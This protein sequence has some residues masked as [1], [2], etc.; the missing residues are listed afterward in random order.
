MVRRRKGGTWTGN[1]SLDKS[2]RH[3]KELGGMFQG[4]VLTWGGSCP[5]FL[6]S[7]RLVILYKRLAKSWKGSGE[8]GGGGRGEAAGSCMDCKRSWFTN[9]FPRQDKGLVGTYSMSHYCFFFLLFSSRWRK[10][11]WSLGGHGIPSHPKA[12]SFWRS[13]LDSLV[14]EEMNVP[15]GTSRKGKERKSV[16]PKSV[17]RNRQVG[18]F[19]ESRPSV[20]R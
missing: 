9:P 12:V 15:R 19:L 8:W 4:M 16:K 3:A 18:F 11:V 1:H 20:P 7:C 17:T 6:S 13:S 2:H 14:E 10:R 5:L